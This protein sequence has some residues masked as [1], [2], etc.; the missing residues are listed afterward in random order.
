M[1]AAPS[2]HHFRFDFFD[3]KIA[4]SGL[5][6]F[7]TSSSSSSTGSTNGKTQKLEGRLVGG[8]LIFKDGDFVIASFRPRP[9]NNDTSNKENFVTLKGHFPEAEDFLR[10]GTVFRVLVRREHHE[11]YGEQYN[12]LA[13]DPDVDDS[14]SA[15]VTKKY[16]DWHDALEA[17]LLGVEGFGPSI[18]KTVTDHLKEE[19]DLKT[20]KDFEK[21]LEENPD[22]FLGIPGVGKKK[23]GALRWDFQDSSQGDIALFQNLAELLMPHLG[24]AGKLHNFCHNIIR[25]K[26]ALSGDLCASIKANPYGLT[27]FQGVSFQQA[28]SIALSMGFPLDNPLRAVAAAVHILREGRKGRTAAEETELARDVQQLLDKTVAKYSREN[29]SVSQIKELLAKS[30]DPRIVARSVDSSSPEANDGGKYFLLAKMDHMEGE[31]AGIIKKIQSTGASSHRID[32]V[33]AVKWVQKRT[34]FSNYATEQVKAIEASCIHPLSVINGGPGTGKSS[35]IQAIVLIY[36]SLYNGKVLL[37][38]PTGKAAQRLNQILKHNAT[39]T[40]DQDEEASTI[41]RLLGWNRQFGCYEHNQT[42]PLNA[43]VV[44]VDEASMIGTSLMHSLLQA[45]RCD[46]RVVFVGDE[47]QLP[48]VDSGYPFRDIIASHKV[49]VTRLSVNFRQAEM[50]DIVNY[51][52]KI[53]KGDPTLP[54]V[55]K[56][57]EDLSETCHF[58]ILEVNDKENIPELVSKVA[59]EF[60]GKKLGLNPREQMQVLCP[61]R[62]RGNVSCLAHNQRLQL[63]L[64]HE[65]ST[66][67]KWEGFQVGDKVMQLRNDYNEGV[68]NGNVGIVDKINRDKSGEA[69][70]LSVQFDNACRVSYTPGDLDDLGLAWACT[71]HKFQ[72]S[73][74]PSIIFALTMADYFMLTRE[75][76]YTTVTRARDWVVLVGETKAYELAASR[77]VSSQRCTTLVPRLQDRL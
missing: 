30:S 29:I 67:D 23:L 15:V 66:A 21:K 7:S 55:R 4:P 3:P 27:T 50:S 68:F 51:A 25:Q 18:A 14:P 9:T 16:K 62:T 61:R 54:P 28:D 33:D 59:T 11:K 43:D 73:E 75:L 56:S 53:N 72:G 58:Q 13:V 48:P 37:A 69:V 39:S 35:I 38:A 41:H 36:Q 49:P 22:Y 45:I 77:R 26:P 2:S 12:I 34:D 40:F 60:F 74:V 20:W 10:D 5:S 57:I 19:G 32:S 46:T 70:G 1:A 44:I 47:D 71:P 65:S 31:I 63:D 64:G 17:Y 76:L 42:N 8:R 6:F 52:D 24:D